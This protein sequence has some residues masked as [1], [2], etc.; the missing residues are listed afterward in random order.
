MQAGTH[1]EGALAAGRSLKGLGSNPLLLFISSEHEAE[2]GTEVPG[3][4]GKRR[5]AAPA[6]AKVS[7]PP[8]RDAP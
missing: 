7:C 1:P 6:P 4:V 5:V 3:T 2:L 8:A